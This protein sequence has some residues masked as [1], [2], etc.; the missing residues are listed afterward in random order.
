[1]KTTLLPVFIGLS[2]A[3]SL[4]ANTVAISNLLQPTSATTYGIGKSV[5]A[6]DLQQ[7]VSFTTGAGTTTLESVTLSFFSRNGSATDFALALYTGVGV[8]GPTGLVTTFSG[9]ATPSTGLETYTPNLSTT[10]LGGTTYW[11][12]ES[13]ISTQNLSGFSL[14]GTTSLAE[15]AGGLPGWS[16]GDARMF[17]NNGGT[18]WSSASTTSGVLQFSVQVAS[19]PDA[20]TTAA[21]LGISLLGLVGVHRRY[22]ATLG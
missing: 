8:G 22:R 11:L 20:G 17:T 21:L 3:G 4:H 12:V 7:A 19:T 15:D 18:S 5:P 13:A 10:L 6:F 1:M 16:I 14:K 2:L 9:N